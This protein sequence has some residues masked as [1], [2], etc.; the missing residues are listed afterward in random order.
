MIRPDPTSVSIRV[1]FR[2]RRVDS[3]RLMSFPSPP[4]SEREDLRDEL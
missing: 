2:P 3:H 1:P 4:S